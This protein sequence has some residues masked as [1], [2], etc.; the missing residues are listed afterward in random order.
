MYRMA[1]ELKYSR[2]VT[3]TDP[4]CTDPPRCSQSSCRSTDVRVEQKAGSVFVDCQVCQDAQMIPDQ[5]LTAGE[6]EW[7]KQNL[8]T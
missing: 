5:L 1:E 6:R 7:L 2:R 4:D 8:S 3:L